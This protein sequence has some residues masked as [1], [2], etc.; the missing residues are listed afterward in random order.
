MNGG[1]SENFQE[2][3]VHHH[4]IYCRLPRPVPFQGHLP[5]VV[6]VLQCLGDL[7]VYIVKFLR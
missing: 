7:T 1:L 5:S 6:W 2:S 3:F 4:Q